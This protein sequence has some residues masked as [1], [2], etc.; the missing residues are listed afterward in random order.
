[1]KSRFVLKVIFLAQLGFGNWAYSTT[2]VP[3]LVGDI[4]IIIP[5]EDEQ[6]EPPEDDTPPDDESPIDAPPT[7]EPPVVYPPD[8]ELKNVTLEYVYDEYGRLKSILLDGESF[9]EYSLDK[10]NNRTKVDYKEVQ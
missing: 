8:D 10:A 9:I 1:M 7:D 6:E 5:I 4:T 2:F 3:I